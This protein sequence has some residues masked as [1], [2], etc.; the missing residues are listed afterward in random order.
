MSVESV[1]CPSCG[2]SLDLSSGEEFMKCQYCGSNI[3][4]KIRNVNSDGSITLTDKATGLRVG[5]V[6]LP[7]GYQAMGMIQPDV[8]SFTYPFGVSASAY[9]ETG[10]VIGYFIGEGYTDRS[11]NPALSG[12]YSEGLEQI[13]KTHYKDFM[14][15]QQYIDSYASTYAT[16]SQASYLKFAEERPMPLYE[17]FNETEAIQDFQRKVEFEKQR[18][19]NS[20]TA[21]DTG[22][23]CKGLCRIYDITVNGADY[24][25]AVS[26]VLKAWRYQMPG[27]GG[28]LGS[29]GNLGNLGKSVNLNKLGNF[30]SSEKSNEIGHLLFGNSPL[31]KMLG[32]T[33]Q[34]AKQPPQAEPQQTKTEGAFNDMPKNS[35]IEWLSDGVFTMLC[36]PQEFELAFEQAFTDFCSTLKLDEGIHEKMYDTQSQILRDIS[37]HTQQR[38]DQMNQQFQSW[39]QLHASQQ[40]AFDSYNQAWW[41]RTNATDAARRS[42]YQSKLASENRMSDS[43]SEAIRGVNT[44]LRPD[45]T[46]VEVSVAYNRAYT[47][48]SGDTLGSSSAFEPIGSWTEMNRK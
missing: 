30:G 48:N 14:D 10:A 13:S 25:F 29:L 28:S 37:Q 19:S 12:M 38:L 35:V 27:I 23:Y 7:F 18:I 34:P 4:V 24:K 16:T 20:S 22:F 5:T 9:S 36:P 21:K 17:P 31:G 1:K 42:A 47:D 3:H 6:H 43:Y 8:S 32:V 33:S 45:G 40:A 11:K 2:A 46:E 26:T 41:N 15:V 39:Q 44:Y